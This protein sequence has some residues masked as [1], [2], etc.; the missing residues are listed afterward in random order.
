M[1]NISS[2]EEDEKQVAYIAEMILDAQANLDAHAMELIDTDGE[3]V[4][5]ADGE[6]CGI[7][8]DAAHA[9]CRVETELDPIGDPDLWPELYKTAI[10]AHVWLL[11]RRSKPAW[12]QNRLP[13]NASVG[14]LVRAVEHQRAFRALG[15]PGMQNH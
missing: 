6:T 14:D 5:T 15:A 1:T 3:E 13:L 8:T 11:R 4:F 10:K 9:L 7:C 2:R 12:W